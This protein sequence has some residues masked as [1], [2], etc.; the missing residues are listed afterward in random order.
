MNVRSKEFRHT[1]H[2]IVRHLINSLLEGSIFR[3]RVSDS[4]EDLKCESM[5]SNGHAK[6]ITDSW[7]GESGIYLLTASKDKTM[8]LWNTINKESCAVFS[9]HQGTVNC[10]ETKDQKMIFSGG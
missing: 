4:P 5:V 3:V 10:V 6:G 9:G 7:L 8:Q 2:L 1:A